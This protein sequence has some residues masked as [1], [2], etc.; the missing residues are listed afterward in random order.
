MEVRRQ[1]GF[2][3]L[4]DLHTHSVFSDG[5]CTPVEIVDAAVAKGLSAV[6]LT[7]H[8]TTDGLSDFIN[9]ASGKKID[10][11]PGAEFSV[12][13]N[14]TELHMLGL[15]IEPAYFSQVS[16]LMQAVTARKEQSNL[17]LIESL[18]RIGIR[19]DYDEIKSATPSGKVNRAHIAT[20]MVQNGYTTTA[21]EAF[22]THLS[23]A[24]GHY[25]EP[26]RLTA[27]EILDF[28]QSIG[29]LSVL[30]HPLLN[31]SEGALARFLPE[32][33][34]RRLV[35][36]ECRYSL[37][38]EATTQLSLSLADAF[39]LLK[40]GGSDFHGTRKPDIEIGVGKGSLNVP[41]EWYLA[42]KTYT[43]KRPA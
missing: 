39:G 42:L 7:D 31:L 12:D 15:F 29:A 5:T 35:G 38:D 17:E 32:A 26:K 3:M 6:A 25:K 10:I 11:V 14:G 30:A 22:E 4:C 8:N 37:Y 9:A 18:C 36:M 43:K 28:I 23:P 13:Y 24:A 34:E 40:S 16:A 2:K 21:A 19:L 27:W 20:A 33:K 1:G 41:Y